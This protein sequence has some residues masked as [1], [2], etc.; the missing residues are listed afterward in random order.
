MN[1]DFVTASRKLG[2]VL[3]GGGTVGLAYHAGVLRALERVGGVQ[4]DSAEVVVGTSAGSLVGAYLRTGWSTEQLWEVSQG[5]DESS[6]TMTAEELAEA[7]RAILAPAFR[8]PL[9]LARRAVGSAYVLGRSF[10]RLPAPQVPSAIGR[11]FPA[12][13]FAMVEGRRRFEQELP[14]AWPDKPLWLTTVD[15]NSG[16]RVVLGRQPRTPL[17][18]LRDGV[19]ASCAIPGV[20]APIRVGDMVLVDG[21]IHSSS[22]LDLAVK[23]GCDVVIASVPM[24]YDTAQRVAPWLVGPR[25]MFAR[26]LSNEVAFARSK[27]AEV[28]LLRPTAA[29]LRMQGFN[30]MKRSGWE[31]V[32][33]AA[34]EATARTLETPRFQSGLARLAAA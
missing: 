18:S 34:Y 1:T 14:A 3:G 15:I 33:K 22:N 13:V 31:L 7:R 29:E 26:Q 12:G 28:L 10:M 24:A 32:A 9:D 2:L 11:F 19:A 21:G 4:P 5:L 8:D 20:Y 17:V 16:R 6:V 25:G 27:G 30:M 23:A